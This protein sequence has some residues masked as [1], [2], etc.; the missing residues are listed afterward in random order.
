MSN[1]ITSFSQISTITDA[2]VFPVVENGLSRRATGQDLKNYIGSLPGASGAGTAGATGATGPAGVDGA[3][4]AAGATGLPGATGAAGTSVS[5]QGST[6]TNTELPY[7]Y[8]GNSGDGYI[9]QDSGHLWVYGSGTWTDVGQIVGPVGATGAAG[10]TGASFNEPATTSVL[11]G[12]IVGHN[13]AVTVAGTLSA[14]TSIIG[15]VAPSNPVAGDQWWDSELG[16]SFTY[17]NGLWVETSPNVGAIGATGPAGAIGATGATPN[18][19]AVAEHIL[20]SD[21]LTYDLGS[22]SSQ[23]RSLYVG[24][25]TIYLG[26][27]ALSIT[28]GELRVNGNPIQVSSTDTGDVT[29]STNVIEGTGYELGLSPGTQFTTGTYTASPGPE[30]GPQYFRVRGGDNYEHL[31]FDTSNNSLFDLYVGDDSKYFKLSKDGPAVIGTNALTWT[32]DNDGRLT[33]PDGT[34]S[35]GATIFANS[36]TYKIQTISFEGSPSNVVSTYEFGVGR[37]TI[38]G[39]GFIYNEGQQGYWALD[40]ANGRLQFPNLARIGYGLDEVLPTEDDLRIFASNTGS[41]YVSTNGTDWKF[42]TDGRTTFPV[43][44]IPLHSYGA[45]GD[46]AGMVA[47]DSGYIYYCSADFG[48]FVSVAMTVQASQTDHVWVDAADWTQSANMATDFAAQPTG[49]TYNGVALTDIQS[50]SDFGPGY[51]LY[52]SGNWS[53]VFNGQ[54]YTLVPGPGADIWKRVAWSVGTW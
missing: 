43:A 23:W 20:P 9:T 47:F 12:V 42:G 25:S 39:N 33:F 36:T 51:K 34:T 8:L 3:T 44:A 16:R 24:T 32:F 35:T 53:G 7:P 48:G 18:F 38:P 41:V 40:G 19:S 2:T 46:K 17:F 10:A 27:T 1:I 15:D 31:H 52:R 5:I 21:N 11:G 4:G 26:G 49:W 6:S 22:T 29:F 37:I 14:I 45:V 28:G 50:A 13:L 30:L 54:D